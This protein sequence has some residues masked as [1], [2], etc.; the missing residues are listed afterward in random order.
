MPRE[1]VLLEQFLKVA[2]ESFVEIYS[3]FQPLVQR[4]SQS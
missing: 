3:K 4:V 1:P 2:L